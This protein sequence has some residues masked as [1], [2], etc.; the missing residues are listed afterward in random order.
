MKKSKIMT[1]KQANIAAEARVSI[2]L[3][4]IA[5][6]SGQNGGKLPK[7]NLTDYPSE[8][9][10]NAVAGED[11]EWSYLDHQI[12][13]RAMVRILR[14]HKIKTQMVEIK[15]SDYF[16]WLNSE[17]RKNTPANRSLYGGFLA[18]REMT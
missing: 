16:Q 7:I 13:N 9:D 2:I 15:K 4:Q 5:V 6:T 12:V 8:A 11:S 1:G 10:Y 18:N 3:E 17:C 14:E